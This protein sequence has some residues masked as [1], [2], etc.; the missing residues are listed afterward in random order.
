MESSMKKNC[1]EYFKPIKNDSNMKKN[2]N[3]SIANE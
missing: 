2:E 1:Y 3:D